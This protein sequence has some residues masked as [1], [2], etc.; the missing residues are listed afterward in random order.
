MEV[1]RSVLIQ[2]NRQINIQLEQSGNRAMAQKGLTAIQ[3][4]ILLYILDHSDRGI[5]LTDIHRE[6]G[7]SMAA[8]SG[9]VKRLR[10]KD[11]VRVEPCA[12]DDRK[13]ILFGTDKGKEAREF[14]DRAICE[15][16]NQLYSGFSPEEL[17]TLDRLQKKML[18]N[19]S[20]LT[21]NHSKESCKQK[22]I[23][24]IKKSRKNCATE[25]GH[26]KTS[27][28]KSFASRDKASI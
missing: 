18:Q 15:A 16:Q 8:M 22:S 24:E 6:F 14:L 19:L 12:R 7:Y 10:E 26:D 1:N 5:S 21:Q 2:E 9:L 13:K 25:K 20:A 27:W 11:Y 3:A 17:A 28:R 4:H 23:S